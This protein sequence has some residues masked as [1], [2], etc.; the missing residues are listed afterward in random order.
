L[1]GSLTSSVLRGQTELWWE[2]FLDS[3]QMV[4]SQIREGNWTSISFESSHANGAS[5]VFAFSWLLSYLV[6]NLAEILFRSFA[7]GGHSNNRLEKVGECNLLMEKV[8]EA[9]FHVLIEY[10]LCLWCLHGWPASYW[11]LIAD[12]WTSGSRF[13]K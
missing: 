8:S 12:K 7:E 5:V 2:F 3:L 10:H 4:G 11:F 9:F 1:N 6:S 13:Q